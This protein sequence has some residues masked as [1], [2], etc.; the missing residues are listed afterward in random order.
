MQKKNA[1]YSGPFSLKHG[2]PSSRHAPT[3]MM[4][5]WSTSF[6]L[7]QIPAIESH[8]NRKPSTNPGPFQQRREHVKRRLDGRCIGRAAIAP[9]C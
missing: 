2:F 4:D 1:D 8:Q 9:T 6:G 5:I 3:M 7:R